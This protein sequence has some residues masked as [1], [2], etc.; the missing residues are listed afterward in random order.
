MNFEVR[1]QWS[2]KNCQVIY[3]NRYLQHHPTKTLQGKT[4][5]RKNI[6]I[7]NDASCIPLQGKVT[8][9]VDI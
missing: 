3:I 5:Q 7:C 4:L 9:V 1:L 2:Q 6:S 8:E